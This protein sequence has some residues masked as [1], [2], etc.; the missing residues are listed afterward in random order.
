MKKILEDST[1]MKS[2]Y[3]LLSTLKRLVFFTLLNGTVLTE[4][5]KNLLE[6]IIFKK[7][8]LVS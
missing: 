1:F 4:E 8:K 3:H 2:I 5:E 7:F 6:I